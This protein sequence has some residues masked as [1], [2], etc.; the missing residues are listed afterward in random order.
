MIP[1]CGNGKVDQIHFAVSVQISFGRA[2]A[3]RSENR[4]VAD[5]KT[6]NARKWADKARCRRFGFCRMLGKS[7]RAGIEIIQINSIFVGWRLFKK[8]LRRVHGN[9]YIRIRN[10][11]S[12]NRNIVPLFHF[13][14]I[15]GDRR[16]EKNT[17]DICRDTGSYKNGKSERT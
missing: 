16:R 6:D 15:N 1:V 4:L 11:L 12:K 8:F 5:K 2:C 17:S 7:K 13:A 9:C 14:F 3:L 10:T